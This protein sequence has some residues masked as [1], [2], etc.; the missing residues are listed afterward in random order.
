MHPSSRGYY[1]QLAW[2]SQYSDERYARRVKDSKL[3][4][5]ECSGWGEYIDEYIGPYAIWHTCG[6]CRGTGKLTPWLRG[7]WLKYKRMEKYE[8]R[9]LPQTTQ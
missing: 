9:R 4:C 5:Q 8:K 7:Q 3:I 6:W 2:K 1:A